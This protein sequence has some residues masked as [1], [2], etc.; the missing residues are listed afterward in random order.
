MNQSPK[1]EMVPSGESTE[2]CTQIGGQRQK[3]VSLPSVLGVKQDS[4]K[5]HCIVTSAFENSPPGGR[6]GST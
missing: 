2:L 1:F 4:R 5:A 3:E 6:R